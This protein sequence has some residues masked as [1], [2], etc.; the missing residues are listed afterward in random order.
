MSGP[1]VA[2]VALGAMMARG[3][4]DVSAG[5]VV[6]AGAGSPLGASPSSDSGQGAV[7]IPVFDDLD[8]IMTSLD[9]EHPLRQRFAPDEARLTSAW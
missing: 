9:V 2:F 4:V 7:Q 1:R 8:G 6:T 3:S 5:G